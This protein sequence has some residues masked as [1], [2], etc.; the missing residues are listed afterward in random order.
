MVSSP[1]PRMTCVHAT[2]TTLANAHAIPLYTNVFNITFNGF[3][4]AVHFADT[5]GIIMFNGAIK[6]F[7]LAKNVFGTPFSN[8]FN[9]VK[10]SAGEKATCLVNKINANDRTFRNDII[11]IPCL[12]V[13]FT[14]T[15]SSILPISSRFKNTANELAKNI[16]DQNFTKPFK[17]QYSLAF[18]TKNPV[19]LAKK[20][21]VCP[22]ALQVLA[23]PTFSLFN[24]VIA[25]PSTATS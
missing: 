19:K 16:A 24:I 7:M 1:S 11:F 2:T 15:I 8:S 13:S 10:L 3:A 6:A 14:P 12:Y 18:S 5:I 20:P 25:H 22:T 23:N 4:P 9:C 17:S 21:S